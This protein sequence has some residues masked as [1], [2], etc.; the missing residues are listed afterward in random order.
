M[1]RILITNGPKNFNIKLCKYLLN[2]NYNAYCLARTHYLEKTM[3][4][5][6]PRENIFFL[7]REIKKY[8]PTKMSSQ[9]IKKY[10]Y[11]TYHTTNLKRLPGNEKIYFG[12]LLS[13]YKN[14]DAK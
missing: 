10:L 14:I 2:K 13:F 11:Y 8:K 5:N 6:L 12:K 4:K 3:K 1:K 9:N 7:P